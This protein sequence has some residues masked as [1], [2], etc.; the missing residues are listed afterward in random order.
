[1]LMSLAQAQIDFIHYRRDRAGY[2][3]V[4]FLPFPWW[5]Q[6]DRCSCCACVHLITS[7]NLCPLCLCQMWQC[8]AWTCWFLCVSLAFRHS[9]FDFCWSWVI[10]HANWLRDK[11]LIT[12]REGRC[13]T[14]QRQDSWVVLLYSQSVTSVCDYKG[15]FSTFPCIY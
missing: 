6:Y 13:C 5:V 10:S 9:S 1:M 15:L 7:E 4:S 11:H 8:E 2:K 12:L 14:E 3:C